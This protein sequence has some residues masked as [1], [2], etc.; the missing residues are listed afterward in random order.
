MNKIYIILISLGIIIS[1]CFRAPEIDYDY[2]KYNRVVGR[3]GGIVTF[4][5]NY[6]N[7]SNL[8]LS[9]IDTTTK[10][11]ELNVPAGALDTDVVFNFYQ[12]DDISV[13]K[14]LSKGLSNVGSKFIY[15][16]PV[17]AS[18]GYHEHDNADLTYHLSL[19]FNEPVT[20]KYYFNLEEELYTIDQKKLQFEFYDRTNINYKLYRLKIPKIDEWGTD[21]NIFVQWNQQDYPIGYNTS[22][23]NDIILGLWFKFSNPTENR[24]SLVNWEEVENVTFD[25][26]NSICFDI[27]TTDYIYVIAQVVNIPKENLPLKI[28]NFI[29]DNYGF[30]V[31]RA[32]FVNQQ[33]QIV[34]ENNFILYFKRDGEFFY[35]EKHNISYSFIPTEV[36]NYVGTNYSGQ[37]IKSNIVRIEPDLS[38]YILKYFITLTNDKVLLFLGDSTSVSYVG[39]IIYDF[40]EQNLSNDITDY[41]Y[42]TFQDVKIENIVLN[43]MPG[44]E[45]YV[46]FIN[47]NQRKAKLY[48]DF[49]GE[50]LYTVYY[51]LKQSE[52]SSSVQAYLDNTFPEIELI[53]INF[54]DNADSSFFDMLLLNNAYIQMSDDGKMYYA[55]YSVKE[56]DLPEQL[57]D[58]IEMRFASENIVEAFYHFENDL[59]YYWLGF[60]E[61]LNLALSVNG[62][63][64]YAD[65]R[66]FDDLPPNARIYIITNH[67]G[68]NQ[69]SDFYYLYDNSTG[70]YKYTFHVTIK[71]G[72]ILLFDRNGNYIMD[73]K[74]GNKPSKYIREKRKNTIPF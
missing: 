67:G 53:S 43:E 17:L 64:F 2:Q 27:Q 11:L 1:G 49:S 41:V 69:F 44:D 32:A 65:G 42:S 73:G 52:I 37:S 25:G 36:F 72:T 23:L 21:R 60:N 61:K 45:Y 7:D 12:Y 35:A 59:G 39:K 5:A 63:V 70:D 28:V 57:V 19:E 29:E 6:A 34:L 62:E 58:S 15:F 68:S 55:D 66:N 16:V 3:D 13:A 54:I 20:V 50:L 48:F 74:S 47:Y 33:F 22:D 8:Y 14:E 24:V 26:D 46:V 56:S 30:Q 4:Y 71:D 10:I 31:S 40:D 9:G 38:D 18:D 51:G